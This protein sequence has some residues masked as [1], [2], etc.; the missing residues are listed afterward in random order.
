[1]SLRSC[2]LGLLTA[3]PMT[4]YEPTTY[5]DASLDCPWHAPHSQIHPEPRRMEE[6]GLV[7]ATTLPRG[8][9]ATKRAYAITDEGRAEVARWVAEPSNGPRP[10]HR[11]IQGACRG[12]AGR[13]AQEKAWAEE[14]IALIDR[15]RHGADAG[16]PRAAEQ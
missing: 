5:F 3:C 12:P 14:G 11:R 4:G 7:K 13:A 10:R 16:K 1:M 6:A 2:L 9:R 8:E 15:P